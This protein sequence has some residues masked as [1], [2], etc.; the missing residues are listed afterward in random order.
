MPIIPHIVAVNRGAY[1]ATVTG[2][3]D[4]ITITP[5]GGDIPTLIATAAEPT[6]VNPGLKRLLDKA[7]I[8]PPP[9]GQVISIAHLNDR[10]AAAK[11]TTDERLEVKSGLAACRGGLG[12]VSG[13]DGLGCVWPALV[14]GGCAPARS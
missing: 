3:V 13:P 9:T 1:L 7:N 8:S 11:M 12:A 4:T 6:M 14:G 5:L 10:L 2:S